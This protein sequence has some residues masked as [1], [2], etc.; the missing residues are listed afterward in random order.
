[1]SNTFFISDTHWGHSNVLTFTKSD[2]SKLRQFSS[3][4]EMDEHMVECWN[5]RVRSND[6]VYHLGDVVM[7]HRHLF[8]VGR[9]NGEKVLIKGN[10]DTAKLS[11]YAPYFKDIR[12][13]HQFDGK[14]LTH[15]P[16]HTDSLARW[17]INIHGHLHSR[18]V[19]KEESFIEDCEVA[20]LML[21]KVLVPDTRY[22]NV[23]VERINYTPISYDEI[24]K[25][26]T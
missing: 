8:Q 14:L 10:H 9:C 11:Q 13:S 5:K 19:M 21:R 24:K 3:V 6:K 18:I 22:F 16:V 7:H 12:G 15:I 1:M 25:A 20:G 4:E 23:G 2:G 26:L 17:S